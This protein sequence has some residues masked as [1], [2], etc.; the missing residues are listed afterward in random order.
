MGRHKPGQDLV[1]HKAIQ[2][3]YKRE[4]VRR[5]HIR[6]FQKVRSTSPPTEKCAYRTVAH[7]HAQLRS[8]LVDAPW[9]CKRRPQADVGHLPTVHDRPHAPLCSGGRRIGQ[10]PAHPNPGRSMPI[11]TSPSSA[12]S[13]IL[14]NQTRFLERT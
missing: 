14:Q 11:V 12:G 7:P 9:R 5:A 2:S 6:L 1:A 8:Q 4:C 10:M 13:H 3:R